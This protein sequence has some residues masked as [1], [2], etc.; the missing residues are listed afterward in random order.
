MSNF[1]RFVLILALLISVPTIAGAL[2]ST[3]ADVQKKCN[4]DTAV[5]FSNATPADVANKAMD[6]ITELSERYM[7]NFRTCEPVH[8]KQTVD[9]FGLKLNYQF[10]INGWV[11]NKCSYYMTG[12]I[13]GLGN[14]IKDVFHLDIKDETIAKVKPIVQCNF[15]QE[16][17][18]VVIDGFVAMQD[19]KADE[20]SKYVTSG[21]V[22][23]SSIKKTS[24]EEEKMMQ[25][26]M[27]GQVCVIPNQEELMQNITELMQP[28]MNSTVVAPSKNDDVAAPELT[29]ENVDAE[30]PELDPVEDELNTEK[31]V[32]RQEG[33]KVNMPQAPTY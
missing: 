4:Q 12:N 10:D 16:E 25:L 30:A 17:L 13:G 29:P 18:D 6:A 23:V 20:R 31:P 19:R 9:V 24:P 15:T 26:L 2:Q 1:K 8:I 21:E 7:T 28:I 32:L 3:S 22:S 5:N 33:P 27:G 14:D 11:D